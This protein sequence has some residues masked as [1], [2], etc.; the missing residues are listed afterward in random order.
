MP[1]HPEYTS[2][3]PVTATLVKLHEWC[4]LL[5]WLA[6]NTAPGIAPTPSMQQGRRS[7]APDELTRIA[8][9]LGLQHAMV[10]VPLHSTRHNASGTIDIL[11]P[12]TGTIIE[13][14]ATARR[15]PHRSHLAQLAVYTL[16]AAENNLHPR[17]AAIAT[18]EPRI[19]AELPIDHHTLQWAEKLIHR[20]RRT[21][22]NPTPPLANQPPQKCRYC[23]HRHICPYPNT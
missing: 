11:D 7:H 2:P 6:A 23:T 20:T 5:A 10:Q 14:K 1:G 22:D 18:P 3:R 15:R 19:I 16:L 13:V 4:P 9:Q 17:R 12:E 8:R 21:I